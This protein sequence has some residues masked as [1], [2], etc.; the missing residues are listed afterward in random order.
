MSWY[1]K[2]LGLIG[3]PVGVSLVNGQ[4]VTGVLCSITGSNLVVQEYLYQSQFATKQYPFNTIQ[5]VN[6]FPGC[7]IPSPLF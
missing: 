2:A 4:G 5:D 1:S 7:S 3:Q 6:P